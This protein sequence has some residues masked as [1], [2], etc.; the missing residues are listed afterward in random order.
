[1]NLYNLKWCEISHPTC[2]GIKCSNGG[3]LKVYGTFFDEL[4]LLMTGFDRGQPV[5][6][7]GS[8][9]H[10]VRITLH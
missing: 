8:P 4:C 1:M 3:E 10:A 6:W 5:G 7:A 9:A 2:C